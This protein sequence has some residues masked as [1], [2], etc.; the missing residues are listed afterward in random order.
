MGLASTALLVE[1]A[2]FALGKSVHEL[3]GPFLVAGLVASSFFL[4]GS[5]LAVRL[6]RSAPAGGMLGF[7]FYLAIGAAQLPLLDRVVQTGDWAR[8]VLFHP[9]MPGLVVAGA[10][11][12]FH[13]L[14]LAGCVVG[15]D[16][17]LAA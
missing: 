11:W 10:L 8:A 1:V 14:A 9:S 17:T 13:W 16:C 6:G 15:A 5:G 3:A 12:P 7:A 4:M 2:W